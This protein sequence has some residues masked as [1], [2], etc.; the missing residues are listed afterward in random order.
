MCTHVI[1]NANF[2]VS[3]SLVLPTGRTW[4]FVTLQHLS[5]VFRMIIEFFVETHTNKSNLKRTIL[6][7]RANQYATAIQDACA[8]LN[9][10]IGFIDCTE[11]RYKDKE[12][13]T[14]TKEHVS[15][16][17]KRFHSFSYRAISTLD[18]L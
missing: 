14:K 1:R 18:R 9:E 11:N 3:R 10:C 12:F 4:K 13:R 5:E 8:S 15:S 17:A 6:S 7:S 2:L 16:D